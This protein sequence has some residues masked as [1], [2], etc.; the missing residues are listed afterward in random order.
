MDAATISK[1]NPTY[2]R[3]Y[4][5]TATIS[6]QLVILTGQY[7]F[8]DFN[9]FIYQDRVKSYQKVIYFTILISTKMKIYQICFLLF[10][11]LASIRIF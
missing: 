10:I 11:D 5:N 7:L 9:G 8:I 6:V 4:F 1:K 2:Y 3:E